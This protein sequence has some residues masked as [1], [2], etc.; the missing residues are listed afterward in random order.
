MCKPPNPAAIQASANLGHLQVQVLHA[1][2]MTNCTMQASAA[3]N[4][5]TIMLRFLMSSACIAKFANPKSGNSSFCCCKSLEQLHSGF[6]C[7]A[8]L[9]TKCE[10]PNPA[11]LHAPANLLD[12]RMF[13]LLLLQISWKR[14]HLH[15]GSSCQAHHH[16]HV[17]TAKPNSNSSFCCYKSLQHSYSGSCTPSSSSSNVYKPPN[18]AAMQA[19][20]CCC[21]SLEH[22]HFYR[23]ICRDCQSREHLWKSLLPQIEGKKKQ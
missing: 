22:P 20:F 21:K 7:Q 16:Q 10:N 12:I 15:S 1:K 23:Q 4:S 14:E 5:G 9:I 11:I 2:L 8:K 18:P 17:Q 3:A 19:S 6:S 13:K